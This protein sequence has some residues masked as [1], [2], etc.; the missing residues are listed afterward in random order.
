MAEW[1][2]ATASK[3][4][5]PRNRDRGFESHSLLQH[6]GLRMIMIKIYSARF[7]LFFG[8]LLFALSSGLLCGMTYDN[9]FLP[10]LDKPIRRQDNTCFF[11]RVQPFVAFA[12]HSFVPAEED[13]GEEAPLFDLYGSFNQASI[14]QALLEI[15]RIDK[16][17]ISPNIFEQ[18]R[19]LRRNQH[20]KFDGGG[21]ALRWYYTLH[22]NFELGGSWFV[23]GAR[24][25]LEAVLH[26]DLK[27]EVERELQQIFNKESQLSQIDR[28]I[29]NK[30]G[31]SDLDLYIRWGTLRH[32]FLKFKTFDA[33]LKLGVI[34]PTGTKPD[35]HNPASFPFGGNGHWGIYVDGALDT[36]LKEDLFAGFN[37]RFI[38][39]FAKDH[40][41][42]LPIKTKMGSQPLNF[43]PLIGSA[44]VEPGFTCVFSPYVAFNAVRN[45][46][47]AFFSYTL[48]KHNHDALVDQRHDQ[49]SI[50]IDTEFFRRHSAWA[51]DYFTAGLTYDFAYNKECRGSLPLVSLDIDIPWRIF[52][53]KR[54]FKSMGI[55]LRI[56]SDLW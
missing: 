54:S 18:Q 14:D 3:A 19:A 24:S 34:A 32:Y 12:N 42:R 41:M 25:R 55:S 37:L 17:L 15:K 53:S 22:P 46:F 29:W 44:R 40:A 7:C 6:A 10:L 4:V 50:E 28:F 51:S 49:K 31:V 56:E 43:A 13:E 16:S 36:E 27:P 45:G 48:I 21:L 39:R 9:R 52:A 2:K 5:I 8:I 26:R 35:I 30:A 1:S 11:L 20:G 23:I 38:Q 47:G 33:G